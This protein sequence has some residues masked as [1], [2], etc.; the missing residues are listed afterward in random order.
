MHVGIDLGTT[1]SAVAYYDEKAKKPVI[2]KNRYG[3][4]VTPS[5]LCFK[6]NE[7]ISGEDAKELQAFG[8]ENSVAFFKRDMG[9]ANFSLNFHGKS[10]NAEDLSALFLQFLI[11]DA[12]KSL[13][14]KITDVVIT[15]PAYFNNHQRVATMRAGERTGRKVLRIINEPTAAAIAYGLTGDDQEKKIMV[16]DLGGGTFDVTVAKINNNDIEVLGT[17][18]DHQLGGKNWDDMLA[19]HM[20]AKFLTDHD[21]DILEENDDYY[22]L[23]LK[24][25]RVKRELTSKS[26]TN[27]SISCK[28]QKASYE[29]T[30]EDF[31][32]ITR[33]LMERTKMLCNNLLEEIGIPWEEL[34]GVLLVGGSTRMRM[35]SEFVENMSGKAPI[36]GIN[37]DEAIALGAAIQAEMD[38]HGLRGGFT[39]GGKKISDATAHSLGMVSVSEDRK[40][41]I[42]RILIPKNTRIPSSA[43]RPF[44]VFSRACRNGETDVYILQGESRNPLDCSILGKHVIHGINTGQAKEIILD[45]A[46]N[47]DLNGVVKVSAIQRSTGSK[48]GVRVDALPEDM[49]WLGQES[50][51][52]KA[53]KV[54]PITVML[55]VDLSGSMSGTPLIEAQRAAKKMVENLDLSYVS[56]GLIV[57]ADSTRLLFEPNQNIKTIYKGIEG[58]SIGMVGTANADHPF[59]KAYSELRKKE[60]KSFLVVLTDGQWS[61][62]SKAIGAADTCKA[63]GIEIT[64]IGFGGADEK[65][66]R[67]IASSDEGALFTNLE[68]LSQSFSNIAQA[69]TEDAK[70][71]MRII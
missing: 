41:F 27:I 39:L 36:T 29:I 55:A 45:I 52:V 20:A 24:A 64:A 58:M 31:N 30:L 9:D 25:E 3:N 69:I 12:E 50:D 26:T 48:L 6:E 49:S 44:K 32:S 63:Q 34:D 13:G 17:D 4:S 65:F 71:A 40:N 60:G 51:S 7:I 11:N 35:V 47:Y 15:V 56:V 61:C 19:L 8:D 33:D 1:F 57:F 68:S 5:V 10:Y 18:G 42:N 37:I 28:G 43:T 2:I 66:L 53:A 21:V 14:K 59:S 46:Y 70:G 54:E 62:Q 16:Y 67:S 38:S 22:E 23:L